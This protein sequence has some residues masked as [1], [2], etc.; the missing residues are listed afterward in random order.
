MPRLYI[1]GAGGH[2]KVAL[3]ALL[4]QGHQV[5]GFI[6]DCVRGE[7]SGLP[8]YAPSELGDA[9]TCNIHFAI[10]NNST[11]QQLQSRWQGLGSMVRSAI[12]PAAVI[13]P[14]ARLGAGCL[15]AAGAVIGPDATLGEGCIV[16]HNA[17]VDHD[18]IVEPYCHIAPGATLGGDVRLGEGCLV[19]AGT[20]ILQCLTIGRNVTIGA[21]AVVIRDLPDN[22]TAVGV[23]ARIIENKPP[24]C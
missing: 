19:G 13:Y 10:G 3:H 23:P 11:R 2:G 7:Y 15:V 6:D 1:Y 4:A 16:N 22:V 9:R 24:S 17:V 21:G 20:N 14:G 18:S 5:A 12:H 8:V